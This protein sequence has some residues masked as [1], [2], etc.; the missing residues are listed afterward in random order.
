VR[1]TWAWRLVEWWLSRRLPPESVDAV[2]GDLQDDYTRRLTGSSRFA[3]DYWILSEARSVVRAFRSDRGQPAPAAWRRWLAAGIVAAARSLGRAPAVTALVI[4]TLGVAFGANVAVFGLLDRLVLRPLPVDQP[5]RLFVVSAPGLPGPFLSSLGIGSRG[6]GG[7]TIRG[8]SLPFYRRLRDRVPVFSDAAAQTRKLVTMTTG[9][10]PFESRGALVTGNYFQML[11]VAAALGRTL[12]EVD[13]DEPDGSMTPIVITHGFWTRHFGTDPGAVGRIIHLNQ[14]AATIVGV[15]PS[16][17][18]GTV[19]GDSIDFFAPV[20]ASDQIAPGGPYRYDSP[21]LSIYTV[22]ARLHAEVGAADAERMANAVYRTLLAEAIEQLPGFTDER[23]YFARA[24]LTLTPGGYAWSQQS[25]L[26]RRL[27]DSLWLLMAMV[28]LVFVVAAGNVSNLMLARGTAR[29]REV[30]VRKALGATRRRLLG[31]QLIETAMLVVAAAG[32]GLLLSHWSVSLLP[33]ILGVDELPPGV[34]TDPDGRAWV[35]TGLLVV[36]AGTATWAG[37]AFRI[38]RPG[39]EDVLRSSG[40][41]ALPA[42]TTTWRRGLVVLQVALSV[43]LL[44]GAAVLTRSLVKV[45]SVDAGFVAE[46]VQTFQLHRPVNDR[47]AVPAAEALELDGL[48]ESVRGIPGVT[49]VTTTSHLPLAG[50]GSGTWVVADGR[51][52]D[53]PATLTDIVTVGPDYFSTLFKPLRSGGDFTAADRVGAPAT[54]I[55][56]ESLARAL[57]GAPDAVGRRL[58]LQ[59]SGTELE[60][61][62]VASDGPNR[63]LRSPAAPELYVPMLQ[64]PTWSRMSV[65]VRSD[66]LIDY[67]EARDA[68]GRLSPSWAV[69]SLAS[70]G[71]QVSATMSRDRMLAGLS[72]TFALLAA[73]LAAAGIFGLTAIQ[74]QRRT[75]EIGVRL[76][77]GATAASVHRLLARE[78]MVVA[79]TGSAAG[80]LTFVLSSRYLESFLFELSPAD[81]LSLALA[82]LVLVGASLIAGIIPASRATRGGP[83]RALRV[84]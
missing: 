53:G 75:P 81:P 20:S 21:Q 34:T 71:D 70:L 48:I 25:T 76:A 40:G 16:G 30:A 26:S 39:A 52:D 31:E 61:V 49:A 62:G 22:T 45:A 19:A 38:T 72:V 33:A 83:S 64:N 4:L 44:C 15:A 2:L 55:V 37:S 47:A 10:E 42:A 57:F 5:D 54:A 23:G 8:A 69:T 36:V 12:T 3:T 18:A 35:M 43:A 17:F 68:V 50:G 9:A 63:T 14:H 6:P 32:T 77:L 60:I 7:T 78:A 73:I 13:D 74:A 29:A 58:A 46:G 27:T 79:G 82:V 24:R 80:L 59:G 1:I 41:P 66:R 67:A 84:L 28:G 51:Q 56:N 11:G 65:V